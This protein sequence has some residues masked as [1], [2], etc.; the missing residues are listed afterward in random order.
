MATVVSITARP[1]DKLSD[2]ALIDKFGEAKEHAG[3]LTKRLDDL[4]D[5]IKRRGLA[6]GELGESFELTVSS[7]SYDQLDTKAVKASMS[8]AWVAEH[9]RPVNRVSI[10]AKRR[11]VLAAACSS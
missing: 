3:L 1:G 11:P 10:S 5:E 7:T 2:S 9:S 6:G 4:K 8:A